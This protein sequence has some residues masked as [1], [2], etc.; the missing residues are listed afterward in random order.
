MSAVVYIPGNI[1]DNDTWIRYSFFLRVL[2]LF[3]LGRVLQFP[4]MLRFLYVFVSVEHIRVFYETFLS[5]LPAASRLFKVRLHTPPMHQCS[6]ASKVRAREH[7]QQ[8]GAS[9]AC[10]VMLGIS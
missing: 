10:W 1:T 3:R 4:S 6:V 9:R 5:M 8:R 2:R 7:V